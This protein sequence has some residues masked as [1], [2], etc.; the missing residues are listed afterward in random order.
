M[1][2]AGDVVLLAGGRGGVFRRTASACNNSY[3]WAKYGTGLPNTV[4]TDLEV[5][6]NRL[7]AGTFGR[8][9]WSIQDV[10]GT[11]GSTITLTVTAFAAGDSVLI[12]PDTLDPNAIIVYG[13]GV[14][15][16]R[17]SFGQFDNLVVNA[18]IGN[19]S[20]QI[21][22]V[23]PTQFVRFPVT[24]N[25]GGSATNTLIVEANGSATNTQATITTSTIG[26]GTGDN[27]FS[28]CGSVTY[29][30]MA[31]GLLEVRTGSGNDTVILAN[32]VYPQLIRTN[33]GPGNDTVVLDG[34]STATVQAIGR[35]GRR[36]RHQHPGAGRRHRHRLARRGGQDRAT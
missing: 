9:A 1:G 30:G 16:G 23:S 19:N 36:R 33:T 31:G 8:G 7:V 34:S 26:L 25:M 14:N 17:F 21:G 15:L 20:V 13:N 2:A 29:V 28:G 6:G 22:N 35:G 3:V 32:G 27:L 12:A 11:L 4:V 10:S 5:Y 24:V 18:G